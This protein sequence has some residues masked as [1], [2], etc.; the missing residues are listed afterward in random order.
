MGGREVAMAKETS[1]YTLRLDVAELTGAGG[2]LDQVEAL[3]PE[4]V[5]AAA[6]G[7]AAGKLAGS[8]APWHPEAAAVLLDIHEGARRLEAS[9][10]RATVGRLGQRRGGSDDNTRR[11]L[12]SVVRLAEALDDDHVRQAARI[13]AR[14]VTAARR[15]RDIDLTD[16]WEPLPRQPGMLPPSCDYCSTFSLRWNRRSGEVRCINGACRD[17]HGRRPVARMVIGRVSGQASLV[18]QD[19]R[20]IA[21]FPYAA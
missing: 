15:I 13:V 14:W 19:G 6:A 11:A 17:E 3:L 2:L 21:H 10:R 1:T 7:A 9:L 18:W 4:P 16:R 12:E 20:T 5:A 8:P